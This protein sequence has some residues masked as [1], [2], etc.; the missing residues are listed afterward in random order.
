MRKKYI[1][2]ELIDYVTL[3]DMYY[4][5]KSRLI[6]RVGSGLILDWLDESSFYKRIKES[7]PFFR[8][9]LPDGISD[10][11][12]NIV[13]NTITQSLPEVKLL[14]GYTLRAE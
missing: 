1:R 13:Y 11:E 2:K 3:P 6:I 10:E 8:D 12:C 7:E 14:L 4:H 5:K 9:E